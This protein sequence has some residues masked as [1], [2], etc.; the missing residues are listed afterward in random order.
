MN[1]QKIVDFIKYAFVLATVSLGFYL[2]K[3]SF[4]DK[5]NQADILKY[6]LLLVTLL[7]TSLFIELLSDKY[8]VRKK[9]NSI[10]E[11]QGILTSTISASNKTSLDQLIISRK[12]LERLEARV[13]G[14]KSISIYGGSLSR[15]ANEY[16]NVF[17]KLAQKGTNLR[18]LLTD[19]ES[20][21]AEYFSSIVIFESQNS[22]EYRNLLRSSIAS[23]KKLKDSYA[24]NCSVKITQNAFPFGIIITESQEGIFSMN[25]EIY[26]HKIP[27]RE[28]PILPLSAIENPRLFSQFSAQFEAIWND[29]TEVT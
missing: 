18:F 14:A 28:R 9:L 19:P 13:E 10:A 21:A 29:A 25:V 4:F 2:S 24:E 23:W 1:M 11:D 17:E 26:G 27:A 16:A 5:V 15:L 20:P 12:S 6:I 22:D 8:F 7:S 3:I